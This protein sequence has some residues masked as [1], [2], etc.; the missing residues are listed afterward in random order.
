MAGTEFYSTAAQIIP[1]LLLAMLV[2]SS[3]LKG[4]IISAMENEESELILKEAQRR[5][6]AQPPEASA[7]IP[8]SATN[9]REMWR[10][11]EED[12]VRQ[13]DVAILAIQAGRERD[14]RR[15]MGLRSGNWTRVRRRGC[16]AL[17]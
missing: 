4:Q 13:L 1:V 10:R 17:L 6:A 11:C 14:L 2:D 8:E 5:V 9:L 12:P 7:P 16:F 15:A 3:L